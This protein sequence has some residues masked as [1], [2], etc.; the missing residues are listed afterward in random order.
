M[1]YVNTCPDNTFR[2]DRLYDNNV[3]YVNAIKG[4]MLV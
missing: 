1:I 2:L 4:K 3:L